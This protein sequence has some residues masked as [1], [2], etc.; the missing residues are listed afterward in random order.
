MSTWIVPP[1]RSTSSP[2]AHRPDPA[3]ARSWVD[4]GTDFLLRTAGGLAD[5]E[6]SRPS[7]V[8]GWTRRHL[9]AHVAEHAEALDRL[10]AR[11]RTG[12]HVARQPSPV[13]RARDVEEGSKLAPVFLRTWV[14]ASA[15]RLATAFDEVLPRAGAMEVVTDRGRH[16][17]LDALPWL[18]AREVLLHTVDLDGP[19]TFDHLPREFLV[20]L[21]TAASTPTS[22]QTSAQTS[23]QTS[24]ATSDR[25]ALWLEAVDDGQHWTVDG[26]GPQVRVSGSLAAL[27]AW[28]T[29]RGRVGLAISDEARLRDVDRTGDVAADGCLEL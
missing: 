25:P 26:T 28:S 20:E 22:A 15:Q 24:T 17:R 1:P 8:P 10:L 5:H 12:V 11:A 3:R 9:L 14:L 21:V 4:W 19:V 2:R 6:L 7:L 13:E 18:R 23:T 29:G 16:R 27:A